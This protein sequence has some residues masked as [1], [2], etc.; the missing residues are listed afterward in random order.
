ME[1]NETDLTSVK[2]LIP[3]SA[4]PASA[5][6]LLDKFVGILGSM[7]AEP[8]RSVGEVSSS[9]SYHE[10]TEDLP[11]S[12]NHDW[13]FGLA[14]ST[15][16]SFAA[17]IPSKVAIRTASGRT[18]SYGELNAKANAFA[19]WLLSQGVQHGEMIPLYM[20]KS[21]ET[22]ISILG[23]LKVGASF[24]PLDPQNPHDRN[25][26]IVQDVKAL[27]IVSDRKNREACASFGVQVVITEDMDLPTEYVE[28]I[29]IAGLTPESVIYAIYTSG[30]TGLPKGVLVQHS[31]VS[32]STEGMI[33]ATAVTSEWNA[34]WVLNYVFDASYYDV[35]T[36][37]SAGATL[38][39]AP[40]DELLSNLAK[41]INDLEIEQ[42]MLTPT[43]TKLITGGPSEVPRLKV[44]NVC[45]EKIDTNILQWAQSIDVYNG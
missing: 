12:A 14:H 21:P 7:V 34:L 18:L 1:I 37:F 22:L 43:I 13:A 17:S 41:Y 32:A 2:M 3:F 9:I 20:E 38:C 24:T 30:S 35:F 8:T 44:L 16:E 5:Q 26:F 23:I 45:G 40:Q 4:D 11:I 19:S 10:V 33:E 31:A 6:T 27:R 15:F 25:A 42:V 28:N 29:K 36:I 39:L